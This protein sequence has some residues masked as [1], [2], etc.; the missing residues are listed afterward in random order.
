M[1]GL[2]WPAASLEAIDGI[3]EQGP[4][5]I[6]VAALRR[7]RP[8]DEVDGGSE[9]SGADATFDLPQGLE[10]RAGLLQLAACRARLGEH[11][12][13]RAAIELAIR[14]HLAHAALGELGRSGGV[15]AVER[16]PRAAELRIR[17][18]TGP[19]E[20]LSSLLPP[21]LTAPQLRQAHQRSPDQRRSRS[22]E[23]LDRCLEHR[24]RL[25]PPA[26]PQVHRAVLGAAKGEHVAASVALGELGD[27]VAPFEG[28]L[29]ITHGRAR[30]DQETACPRTRDRDRG[31]AL[32]SG[33]G[34]F[35]EAAHALLHAS[36]CHQ[37]CPLEGEPEHLQIG[38]A[39][40]PPELGRAAPELPR[41]SGFATRVGHVALEEGKPAV[42]GSRL[43]RVEEAMG[44]SK[45]TAGDRERAVEVEL[46]AGQPSRHPGCARG[47]SRPL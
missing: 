38:H 18:R 30:R 28:S 10:R 35:V 31:L 27:P 25:R 45:P 5:P 36:A 12:K 14:G 26:P 6:V 23:V 13:P 37:R 39:E 3:L 29:V 34:C 43:E 1:R 41:L 46:I 24:V 19:V 47:V 22:A 40:P 9:G 8:L 15:P 2:E 20:Q 44:A 7:H 4:G 16:H 42:L 11:L 33:H 32:Q 17:G 21:A